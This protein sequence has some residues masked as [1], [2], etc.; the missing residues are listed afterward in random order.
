V[1]TELTPRRDRPR[2]WRLLM[3]GLLT[4]HLGYRPG[5]AL[6]DGAGNHRNGHTAKTVKTELGEV[7]V[8]SP[9][10]GDGTF[11]P[12]LVAKRQ[13]RLAGSGSPLPATVAL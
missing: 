4:E 2:W 13:T 5:E 7:K 1:G 9:R 6:P 8:R 3:R 12:W 11:D 10:D